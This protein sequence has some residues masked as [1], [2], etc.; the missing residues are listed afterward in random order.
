MKKTVD[1][2]GPAALV[3]GASSGIGKAFADCLA[4]EGFDLVLVARREQ[5]LEEIKEDLQSRFH[6]TVLSISQDL[7]KED[8]S[9]NIVQ[10]ISNANMEIGLMIHNAGTGSHGEFDQ[11][12]IEEEMSMIDLSCKT[13]LRLTHSILPKMKKKKRG[14]IIFVSSI[15]SRFPTPFMATYSAVKSFQYD[16]STA[17]NGEYKSYGIDVLALLPG[18][19][20]TEFFERND[21]QPAAPFNGLTPDAV[22]RQALKALG[23]KPYVVAG[24]S[25]KLFVFLG[26][27]F[28][29][30]SLIR[31]NRS[32]LRRTD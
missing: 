29:V 10:Q 13:P 4:A 19:T 27:F 24:T 18:H 25:N 30:S 26:R 12:D 20:H 23:K 5:R 15:V 16:F 9:N 3:T 31:I 17:L 7:A 11:L 8:A 28:P 21:I 1:Q 32:V 6:V 2:Y 14:G 22:A